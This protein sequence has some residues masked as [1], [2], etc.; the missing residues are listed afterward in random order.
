[1]KYLIFAMMIV[2]LNVHAKMEC[3]LVNK[4]FASDLL[5]ESYLR[6]FNKLDRQELILYGLSEAV[7]EPNQSIAVPIFQYL[8]NSELDTGT[9]SFYSST[10]FM[11][12]GKER[13]NSWKAHWPSR[14]HHH[15][16]PYSFKTLCEEYQVSSAK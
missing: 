11:M 13:M 2:S 7:K 14:E 3:K 15:K 9:K 4:G 5:A 6:L 1:M 12:L 16:I 10:L 8:F